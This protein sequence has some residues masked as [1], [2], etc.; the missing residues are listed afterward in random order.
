MYDGWYDATNKAICAIHV[1]SIKVHGHQSCSRIV[2]VV[3][4]LYIYIFLNNT[5]SNDT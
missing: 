4:T 5:T 2:H 1:C 3:N